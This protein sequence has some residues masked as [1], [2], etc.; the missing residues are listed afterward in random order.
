MLVSSGY[1]AMGGTAP[2]R[3]I[4][5]ELQKA[6]DATI[7]LND[8]DARRLAGLDT[9]GS[10]ISLLDFYGKNY[11]FTITDP[12]GG[13][14]VFYDVNLYA[15]AVAAGW[16]RNAKL[17]FVIGD[18]SKAL[19]PENQPVFTS[20]YINTPS[21][22]Y[23]EGTYPNGVQIINYGYIVGK[24][25]AGGSYPAGTKFAG[26]YDG[27]AGQSAITVLTPVTIYNY[28][29]I[30]GGGGGG[31]GGRTADNASAGGGAGGA[32]FGDTVVGA[33]YAGYVSP[34]V[35]T[36]GKSGKT[37]DPPYG[38]YGTDRWGYNGGD[39]GDLGQPGTAGSPA[40]AYITI[41]ETVFIEG[42][43]AGGAGGSA[44]RVGNQYITWGY[45]GTIYG[46]R[47]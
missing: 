27:Q 5:N 26:G 37:L 2:N 15:T 32:C 16:D 6:G 41:R 25:G 9:N 11:Q 7:G 8:T 36:G 29:I 34:T 28:G 24:G 10:T 44:I 42:G 30:G 22:L 40:D 20:Y 23:I 21:A 19:S 3:S 33:Y 47:Y 39:G 17:I 4:S 18:S 13:G 1:I 38:G 45:E 46:A 12:T 14:K 31:G 43:G 35:T